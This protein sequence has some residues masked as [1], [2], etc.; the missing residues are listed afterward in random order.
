MITD[1]IASTF[2]TVPSSLNAEAISK[3]SAGFDPEAQRPHCMQSRST[4]SRLTSMQAI[5]EINLPWCENI[6]VIVQRSAEQIAIMVEEACKD[7]KALESA[8]QTPTYAVAH[9]LQ[10][11]HCQFSQAITAMALLHRAIWQN[12]LEVRM[13]VPVNEKSAWNDD[14]IGIQ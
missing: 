4:E 2:M 10:P 14:C 9:Y 1:A 12:G 13:H 3:S 5:S 8:Y 7:A 11:S 6:L